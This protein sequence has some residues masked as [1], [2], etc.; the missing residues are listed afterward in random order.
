MVRYD[1]PVL[2][3]GSWKRTKEILVKGLFIGIVTI[4]LNILEYTKLFW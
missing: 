3:H 2:S 4:I 1:G